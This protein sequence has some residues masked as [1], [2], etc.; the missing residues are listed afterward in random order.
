MKGIV[1][2]LVALTIVALVGVYYYESAKPMD[3]FGVSL[4]DAGS[5]ASQGMTAGAWFDGHYATDMS[6]TR[7]GFVQVEAGHNHSF[8]IKLMRAD[9]RVFWESSGSFYAPID[10]SGIYIIHI[11]WTTKQVTSVTH[12]AR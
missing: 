5:F 9:G 6:G 8:L 7:S 2:V 3:T 1:F 12:Q 4:D 10:T 11:D